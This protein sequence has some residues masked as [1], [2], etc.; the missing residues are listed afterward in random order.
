ML[1]LLTGV[2]SP[3]FSSPHHR[4]NC[5]WM[6]KLRQSDWKP[7]QGMDGGLVSRLLKP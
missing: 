4:S 2:A 5:L 7:S 6:G 1:C 3:H